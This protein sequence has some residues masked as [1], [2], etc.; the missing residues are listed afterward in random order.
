MLTSLA[1]WKLENFKGLIFVAQSVC[2]M[3]S[4]YNVTKKCVTGISRTYKS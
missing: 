1:V 2:N 4:E 3:K